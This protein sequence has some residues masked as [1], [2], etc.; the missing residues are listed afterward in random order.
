MAELAPV[1]FVLV[2]VAVISLPAWLLIRSVR[3]NRAMRDPGVG[4]ALAQLAAGKGW[5]YIRTRR[6]VRQA[7]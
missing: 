2:F 7:L 6:P 5:C 1:A 4:Q 3:R